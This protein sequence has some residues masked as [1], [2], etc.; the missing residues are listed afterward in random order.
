MEIPCAL[1]YMLRLY[2]SALYTTLAHL[3][4]CTIVCLHGMDEM[5]IQTKVVAI[6]IWES[7]DSICLTGYS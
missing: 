2:V 7:L 6:A 5:D 3:L 1:H 4:F